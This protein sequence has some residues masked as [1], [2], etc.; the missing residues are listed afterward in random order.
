MGYWAHRKSTKRNEFGIPRS[1]TSFGRIESRLGQRFK[2]GIN[3]PRPVRLGRHSRRCSART[4]IGEMRTI[5]GSV[6]RIR[7]IKGIL[8]STKGIPGKVQDEDPQARHFQALMDERK[9][10]FK[11][12]VPSLRCSSKMEAPARRRSSNSHTTRSWPSSL[13]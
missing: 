4:T 10:N 7:A 8:S 12:K 5:R 1:K 6:Q 3:P 13:F 11:L 2:L 9:I